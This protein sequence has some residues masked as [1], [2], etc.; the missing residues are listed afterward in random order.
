MV[1]ILMKK[2]FNK[3]GLNENLNFEKEPIK[4]II[5]NVIEKIIK[6]ILSGYYDL[7]YFEEII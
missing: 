1:N 2:K 7:N 5:I 3:T 4:H 6:N